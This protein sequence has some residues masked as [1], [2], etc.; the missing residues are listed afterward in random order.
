MAFILVILV[1]PVA[2]TIPIIGS[3]V[4]L[5]I[6]LIYLLAPSSDENKPVSTEET[7]RFK[8]KSRL[9]IVGYAVFVGCLTTFVSDKRYALAL[10][11]GNLSVGLSLLANHFKYRSKRIRKNAERRNY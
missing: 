1:I 7:I 6:I 11:V 8:K 5:S 10:A 9:A 3:S 2:N 4:L